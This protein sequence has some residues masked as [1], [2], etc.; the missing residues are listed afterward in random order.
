[1]P[2]TL[3]TLDTVPDGVVLRCNA[4]DLDWL[5]QFL[6]GFGCPFTVRQPPELVAALEQ[7]ARG[8]T[9]AGSQG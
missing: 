1:V 4:S 8:G 7:I 5:A 2:A 6:I 3:G 9:R